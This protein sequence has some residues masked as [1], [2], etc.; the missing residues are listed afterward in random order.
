MKKII[1]MD[2]YTL[3]FEGEFDCMEDFKRAY[4]SAEITCT[5]E[6]ENSIIVYC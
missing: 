2:N 3:A 6:T 4:P 5:E 1:A